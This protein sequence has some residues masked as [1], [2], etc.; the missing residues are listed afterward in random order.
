MELLKSSRTGRQLPFFVVVAVLVV[1]L[2]AS[3][4]NPANVS[5]PASSGLSLTINLSLPSA[6]G[7]ANMLGSRSVGARTVTPTFATPTSYSVTFT[8]STT[9]VFKTVTSN[10]TTVVATGLDVATYTIAV[11]GSNASSQVIVAGSSSINLA[12]NPSPLTIPLSYI[13]NQGTGALS[14]SF[15]LSSVAS[16]G[17]NGT[18]VVGTPVFQVIAPDGSTQ[19]PTLTVGSSPTYSWSPTSPNSGTYQFYFQATLSTGQMVTYSDSAMVYE[20]LTTTAAYTASSSNLLTA[21]VQP[22][23]L[24]LASSSSITPPFNIGQ[25]FALTPTWTPASPTNT[26]LV[27]SSSAPSVVSVDQSGNCHVLV[28]ASSAVITAQS[29]ANPK[30]LATYSVS[31]APLTLSLSASTL[32]LTN[33]GASTTLT[34]TEGGDATGT[35]PAVTLTSLNPS[36]ATV[37]STTTPGSFT[38]TPGSTSGTATLTATSTVDPT[39]SVTCSV[40]VLTQVTFQPNLPTGLTIS[41]D[42][43]VTQ[44]VAVGS[45]TSVTIPSPAEP[46]S[47]TSGAW[48][49]AGWDTS[50]TAT[51]PTYGPGTLVPVS[52]TNLTLYAVW[53]LNPQ[54]AW[55]L[56][57]PVNNTVTITGPTTLIPGQTFHSVATYNGT[58]NSTV[59]WFWD[60]NTTYI[61]TTATLSYPVPSTTTLGTHL[62]T[63]DFL[64]AA[65]GYHYTATK[66]VN[67]ATALPWQLAAPP[68]SHTWNA[69]AYGNG[70]FVGVASDGYTT[71]ST[72]MGKTWSTPVLPTGVTELETIAW[73]NNT[74][75]AGGQVPVSGQANTYSVYTISSSDGKTWSTPVAQTNL[76]NVNHNS[77]HVW[78]AFGQGSF[79]FMP[80]GDETGPNTNWYS[81]TD[82]STWSSANHLVQSSEYSCLVFNGTTFAA[83]GRYCTFEEFNVGTSGPTTYF[84][85]KS[86]GYSYSFGMFNGNYYFN[87]DGGNGW[88]L[89]GGLNSSTTIS[90]MTVPVA[91]IDQTSAY[92]AFYTNQ[93]VLWMTVSGL[94]VFYSTDGVTFEP[95]SASFP[96]AD[97]NAP[98]C[99]GDGVWVCLDQGSAFYAN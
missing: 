89:F 54:W 10:S 26:Q 74:F 68:A 32:T 61:G 46:A 31:V 81:S 29:V 41:T 49:F 96:G 22:T 65:T 16:G 66:Q 14:V 82:G 71:Y 45:S 51:P 35:N 53:T 58:T 73:G 13:A 28:P 52:N 99:Y 48:Y 69:I 40:T 83:F 25:T 63:V 36:I 62:L 67:V 64:D 15:D 43:A 98:W 3:C 11:S 47:W 42:T 86:Q 79:V 30:V 75:V 18:T 12:T 34:V 92:K 56:P 80:T 23:S 2:V 21:L 27:W 8:N 55:I 57:P 78:V 38:V 37:A 77:P 24:A 94:G 6:P 95:S 17:T 33:L 60:N 84:S 93:D 91:A 44:L 20:N 1:A 39:V 88:Y 19:N 70:T 97:Y 50:K 4:T 5:A 87:E 7:Q 90:K 76:S 9:G 72:D 59:K 85:T